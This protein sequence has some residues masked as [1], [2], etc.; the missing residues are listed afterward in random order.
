MYKISKLTECFY[1]QA[2]IAQPQIIQT[3]YPAIIHKAGLS[4]WA[5][6]PIEGESPELAYN[7]IAFTKYIN[8][9]LEN[10]GE[11]RKV[12]IDITVNTDLSVMVT[13]KNNPIVTNLLTKTWGGAMAQALKSAKADPPVAPLKIGE[14]T[15]YG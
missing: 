13:V 8:P 4:P 7:S 9:A 1:R 3:D 6:I 14:I 11:T 15:G 2:Q 5:R 12:D 10:A